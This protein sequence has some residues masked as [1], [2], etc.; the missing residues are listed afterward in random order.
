MNTL[1]IIYTAFLEIDANGSWTNY[2]RMKG[3]LNYYILP[4]AKISG[5]KVVVSVNQKSSGNFSNVAKSAELRS[6]LASSILDFIIEFDLD[7]VDIDWE[8]PSSSEAQNFTLL[9]KDIHEAVKGYDDSLLITAA[10][11]GGMWAPPKYDLPN[12]KQYIDYINLMTYSMAQSNG[13]YQNSLYKSTKGATL[14]SCSIEESIEIYNDLGVENNKILLGIPF[15]TT[16][17]TSSGGPGSKTGEGKSVWYDVM[18]EKYPVSETMKEYFDK[19]CGVPYRYDSVNKIFISYD[20]E[21]SI[22]IKCEYIN[23]LGLAGIMYWQYG[24]DVDDMLTN[25]IDQYINR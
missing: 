14:V 8:T 20:N 24:Q 9:M 11:G 18:L 4:K 16:V 10:I 3:N 2:E 25:A 7:G 22:K 13:Y 17:Q 21:Q 15:Y 5:T 19:E 23:T 6:K 12:S 1:D